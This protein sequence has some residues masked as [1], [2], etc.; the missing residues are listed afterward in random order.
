MFFSQDV[1]GFDGLYKVDFFSRFQYH[2]TFVYHLFKNDVPHEKIASCKLHLPYHILL[3][4]R[5][6]EPNP[7]FS[8]DFRLETHGEL[9]HH[10]S[11]TI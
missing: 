11:S 7:L 3:L 5:N 9:Q 6:M 10:P 4:G 1:R 2:R 8:G